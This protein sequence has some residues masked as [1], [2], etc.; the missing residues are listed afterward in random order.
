MMDEVAGEVVDQA[1]SV[2]EAKKRERKAS[3]N[4]QRKG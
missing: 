2:Q 4:Y 1:L 3:D